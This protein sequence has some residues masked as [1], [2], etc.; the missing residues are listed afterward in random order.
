MN[1]LRSRRKN[2]HLL[3]ALRGARCSF[4]KAW[5]ISLL[6]D[7]LTTI[8]AEDVEIGGTL[9]GNRV[10]SP[11][12]INA[13]TGGTA[14]AAYVNDI[15]ARTAGSF[16]VPLAVGSQSVALDNPRAKASFTRVRKLNPQG[17]ILANVSASSSPKRALTAVE[18]LDAQVLQ[19]HLNPAQEM[20][21]PEGDRAHPNLLENIGEICALSPVPVMV[22]EVGFGIAGSQ[23]AKLSRANISALDVS[24]SG[25]TNFAQI[26]GARVGSNWWLPFAEWGLPTPLCVAEA[27]RAHPELPIFASGGVKNGLQVAQLMALGAWGA[28]V[29][30]EA[31]YHT[32]HG[33][34]R[35]LEQWLNQLLRQLRTTIA[36]CGLKSPRELA[37]AP[38]MITGKL[39]E[40]F[41]LRGFDLVKMANR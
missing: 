25:G 18:M 21:M 9:W 10:S 31:L 3:L 22:K 14:M 34:Q 20:I 13:I 38:V 39:G 16:Q 11:I 33:G 29:A 30:G 35:A 26:E 4:S 1:S 24:G 23:A 41:F 5:E 37:Q 27:V 40:L 32:F 36:L 6:H 17:I 2:E 15:L 19:L 8:A 28:G 7:C 12:Y